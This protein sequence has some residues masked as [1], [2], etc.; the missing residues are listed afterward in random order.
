MRG[1]TFCAVF[2]TLAVSNVQGQSS[3]HHAGGHK[4]G[5]R[6]TVN[7]D[8]QAKD[9]NGEMNCT[10]TGNVVVA[11]EDGK[12]KQYAGVKDGIKTGDSLKLEYRFATHGAFLG[13]M[14]KDAKDEKIIT[15]T[16]IS[17]GN[18]GN[19][20]H[21][22]NGLIL[23]EETF[24]EVSFLQ[25]YIRI[26]NIFGD[27]YLSRYYKNDWHGIF[28]NTSVPDLAT[29]TMTFNC[30]HTFDAMENIFKVYSK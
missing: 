22:K 10:V 19:I 28:I 18:K 2:L 15:S 5:S 25:D 13:L 12:F 20:K 26:S 23:S 4:S 16:Y 7:L 29:H 14:R 27:F 17:L 11:S 8:Q 6:M 3:L 9:T 21:R 24:G 1:V 30:R